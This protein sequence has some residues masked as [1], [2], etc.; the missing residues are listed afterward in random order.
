MWFLLKKQLSLRAAGPTHRARNT[1]WL[2]IFTCKPEPPPPWAPFRWRILDYERSRARLVQTLKASQPST[3]GCPLGPRR[4]LW[5]DLDFIS[6]VGEGEIVQPQNE[7]ERPFQVVAKSPSPWKDV[8]RRIQPL[9][10]LVFGNDVQD[11][12]AKLA[13]SV[14]D[15]RP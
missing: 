4:S 12:K 9:F 13:A 7:Q 3:K 14:T 6:R 1:A 11:Y 10:R 2:I 5:K 15:Q 8:Q